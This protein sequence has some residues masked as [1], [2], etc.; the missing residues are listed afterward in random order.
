VTASSTSTSNIPIANLTVG[1]GVS[2]QQLNAVGTTIHSKLQQTAK[3]S[4]GVGIL[5]KALWGRGGPEALKHVAEHSALHGLFGRLGRVAASA[6]FG[7]L[8]VALGI[9]EAIDLAKELFS[10][11][12]AAREFSE[13]VEKGSAR[14]HEMAIEGAKVEGALLK[15]NEKWRD[16]LKGRDVSTALEKLGRS[17][18]APDVKAGFEDRLKKLDDEEKQ[19]REALAP[20]EGKE[21]EKAR[22]ET[23][24][25]NIKKIEQEPTR[26]GGQVE[27]LVKL[28]GRGLEQ[29]AIGMPGGEDYRQ[30]RGN[31]A[32]SK[33]ALASKMTDELIANQ[34]EIVSRAQRERTAIEEQAGKAAKAVPQGSAAASFGGHAQLSSV[35]DFARRM[36]EAGNPKDDAVPE[37]QLRLLQSIADNTSRIGAGGAARPVVVGANPGG[38]GA[39]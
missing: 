3:Q 34:H 23:V 22:Q 8:G 31:L 7:G 18:L 28:G 10:G 5:E 21:R 16:L 4:E 2:P 25:A 15:A 37:A 24:A 14:L 20:F 35:E 27:D 39:P 9:H 13:N 11:G 1:I 29:L 32:F 6:G 30:R 26:F 38:G 36:I 17:G 19:A 12:E 33:Y